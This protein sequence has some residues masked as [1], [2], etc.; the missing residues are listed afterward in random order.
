M[1]NLLAVFAFVCGVLI[2]SGFFL[3]DR[4]Q[5]FWTML[6]INNETSAIALT[7]IVGAIVAIWGI[8]SQRA[9]ERQKATLEHISHQEAD[10]DLIEARKEF[11][12]LAKSEDG[13]A[14]FSLEDKET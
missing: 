3:A 11:I 7:G 2:T 10:K 1:K 14:K 4:I 6:C 8:M 5:S 12:K 9:I 13:L